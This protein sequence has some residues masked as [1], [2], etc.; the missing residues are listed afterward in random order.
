[1]RRALFATGALC[2]AL[3]GSAS[4]GAYVPP[5]PDRYPSWTPAGTSLVYH[6]QQ[7]SL[8]AIAPDGSSRRR[9]APLGPYSGYALAPDGRRIAAGVFEGGSY[10]LVVVDGARRLELGPV[11]AGMVPRWSPDGTRIAFFR[12][13]ALVVADATSGAVALS[14]AGD[15]APLAWSPDGRRLAA[16]AFPTALELVDV[17]TGARRQLA[18]LEGCCTNGAA[19]SPDGTRLAVIQSAADASRVELVRVDGSGSDSLPLRAAGSPAGEVARGPV[20]WTP[21]GG[22]LVYGA[23]AGNDY[24]VYR[25]DLATRGVTRVIAVRPPGLPAIRFIAFGG[26]LALSPDGT[27]VAFVHGGECRDKVGVHVVGLD[28]RG[29]RR[30]TNGCRVNGTPRADRL[31]GTG[32]PDVLL[33]FAGD[34]RLEGVVDGVPGDTLDGGLGNDTLLGTRSGDELRGGAGADRLLAGRSGDL[35]IGGAGRDT[36]AGEGGI[37]VID[38]F[39]GN[40]DVVSCGTNVA[41]TPERDV[42]YVDRFD[43]V[44]RDCEVV[45]RRKRLS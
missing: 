8:D 18:A 29:L 12:G 11:A 16:A 7:Q 10:R 23:S 13:D 37:D 6:S 19:W 3:G 14:V 1:M 25:L 30:L 26:D 15:L 22:A 21:D 36:L 4:A 45:H 28:G 44:S 35:L 38:A 20:W 9:L 39:D 41:R 42:A 2:L 40:R 27:R 33:G 17:E 5:A 34:D 24:A 31:R 32:G 43:A